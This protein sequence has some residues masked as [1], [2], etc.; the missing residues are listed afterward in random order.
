MDSL[1]VGIQVVAHKAI[2]LFCAHTNPA[3]KGW[4]NERTYAA[5]CI[6]EL[7][8][9]RFPDFLRGSEPSTCCTEHHIP[10]ETRSPPCQ[11]TALSITHGKHG[12]KGLGGVLRIHQGEVGPRLLASSFGCPFG[13]KS[14]T[15][16]HP[17][18]SR[19]RIDTRISQLHMYCF[20]EA[21]DSVLAALLE[22]LIL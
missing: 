5:N 4:V 16:G 18:R 8:D 13:G 10:V 7:A 2:L 15:F 20:V 19:C 11:R 21:A 6:S 17:F 12:R 1:R 22:P 3:G 9:L 14:L